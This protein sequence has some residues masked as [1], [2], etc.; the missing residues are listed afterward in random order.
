MKEGLE[1]IRTVR[2]FISTLVTRSFIP[3]LGTDNDEKSDRNTTPF[4]YMEL[5]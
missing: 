5:E 1:L 2:F 4:V 3:L